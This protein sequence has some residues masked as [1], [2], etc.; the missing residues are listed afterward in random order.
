MNRRALPLA[1]TNVLSVSC[2][3]DAAQLATGDLDAAW[4]GMPTD[5]ILP[6]T[7]EVG[8]LPD[9]L[10][11][12]PDGSASYVL[13]LDVP[14]GRR[15]M[16]PA[17]GLAYN[18]RGGNG[19]FG[20]G[21]SLS[22][23]PEGITR[24]PAAEGRATAVD[25]DDASFCWSGERLVAGPLTDRPDGDTLCVSSVCTEY[26]TRNETYARI[27][28]LGPASDPTA[29]RV[30]TR[31]GRILL[32]ETRVR[33]LQHAS[34]DVE[35][36]ADPVLEGE[37]TLEWALTRELDRRGNSIE[38]SYD[39]DP[40]IPGEPWATHR[41]TEIRYTGYGPQPGNRSVRF[42]YEGRPDVRDRFTSGVQVRLDRRVAAIE[43]WGPNVSGTE[44]LQWRYALDYREDSI[45]GRSLLRLV[46]RSDANGTPEPSTQ[47]DWSLGDFG[48][49]VDE[50]YLPAGASS[51][52][53]DIDGDGRSDL[54]MQPRTSA[55]ASPPVTSGP[56]GD[57][58]W[59]IRLN[60]SA[61]GSG[62][63]GP[64]TCAGF[65]ANPIPIDI[66][67]DGR[68]N[69]IA[70]S[71]TTGIVDT[72]GYGVDP[73]VTYGTATYAA[74]S[75]RTYAWSAGNWYTLQDL[76]GS[77]WPGVYRDGAAP[78]FED[79]ADSLY[80]GDFDG[81]GT[82]DIFRRDFLDTW[83]TQTGR[84]DLPVFEDRDA[85]TLGFD[86][87]PDVPEWTYRGLFR[88]TDVEGDGV[89]DFLVPLTDDPGAAIL[90]YSAACFETAYCASRP[91]GLSA[92]DGAVVGA[93]A[94]A[95]L[96][97]NYRFMDV[98]GDGLDDVVDLRNWLAPT[99]TRPSDG[100]L[101]VRINT[102]N[103]YAPWRSAIEPGYTYYPFEEFPAG[104]QPATV[105]TR[106]YTLD[107][108]LDGLDDFIV[109]GDHPLVYVSNGTTFRPQALPFTHDDAPVTT[110][111]PFVPITRRPPF[112]LA[113]LDGN[114]VAD[115]L[116]GE[117]LRRY[118]RTTALPD[119][120][121]AIR[122][123]FGSRQRIEYAVLRDR[124]LEQSGD[125]RYPIGCGDLRM[126]VVGAIHRDNGLGTSA[127][128]EETS[129]EYTYANPRTDVLRGAFL[130]FQRVRRV[131]PDRGR[132]EE[133]VF[134]HLERSDVVWVSGGAVPHFGLARLPTH[135]ASLTIVGDR[136]I[137]QQTTYSHEEADGAF[138][139]TYELRTS[140]VESEV[141]DGATTGWPHTWPADYTSVPVVAAQSL[142]AS[143][144]E[145]SMPETPGG[146]E[147][148]DR[149]DNSP[150]RRQT[151]TYSN[152]DHYGNARTV[153]TTTLTGRAQVV[154]LQFRPLPYGAPGTGAEE[155]QAQP[156]FSSAVALTD[157]LRRWLISQPDVVTVVSSVPTGGGE[158]ET[159]SV[160][161]YWDDYGL[162]LGSVREP[163][164]PLGD[165]DALQLATHYS[166]DAYG[167]V[168][169]V[170]EVDHTDATDPISSQRTSTFGYDSDAAHLRW[171]RNAAGHLSWIG[172]HPSLGVP[173]I[174]VDANGAQTRWRYDGFGRLREEIGPD[175]SGSVVTYSY[176]N[177]KVTVTANGG[178]STEVMLD[179]L[180]RGVRT[181]SSGLGGVLL[182]SYREYDGLGRVV[183]ERQ[184]RISG[185]LGRAVRPEQDVLGR[186]TAL[187]I[188]P[189]EGDTPELIHSADYDEPG[190]R[191]VRLWDADGETRTLETDY[192]GI[193]AHAQ[194]A[195]DDAVVLDTSYRL[196]PFGVLES[197]IDVSSSE[198]V[199]EHDRLGRPRY[200]EDPDRGPRTLRYN[201]WN[202]LVETDD[203]ERG[204]ISYVRDALGRVVQRSHAHG[205]S[206]YVWDTEP[207]GLGRL[208][209]AI[210]DDG[211]SVE[212]T[213]D[214]LGRPSDVLYSIGGSPFVASYH[215]DG[216]GRVNA[217]DYPEV[218]GARLRVN[219]GYDSSSGL[220]N[221][222]YTS[223]G[224]IFW[225]L[226]EHDGAVRPTVMQVGANRVEQE[227]DPVY[228]MQRRLRVR[229][230]SSPS[231]TP[232][233]DLEANL[234]ADGMLE[235]R[236]DHVSG[237][238][239]KYKYDALD[240]VTSYTVEA[241]SDQ[242]IES[243]R[244]TS[245]GNIGSV[246]TEVTVGGVPDPTVSDDYFYEGSTGGGPHAVSFIERTTGMSVVGLPYGYD[247]IGRQTSGP[248]RYVKFNVDGLPQ[249]VEETAGT[250]QFEYDPFGQRAVT[251]ADDY[252]SYHVGSL[253]ERRENAT[254]AHLNT[255]YV[256]G[257]TGLIAVVTEPDTGGRQ[258][259]Y[260]HADA[261]GT[262]TLVTSATGA[263][264]SSQL[265]NPFGARL[266]DHF[267][268][269]TGGPPTG[270]GRRGFTGH[271]DE[272]EIGLIDMR[273][274]F[275]DPAARRFL[276]P[277]P[278][279][280]D[281]T[282][283]QAFNPYS[284]VSNMGPNGV[285]PS[286]YCT[287]TI[288]GDVYTLEIDGPCRGGPA[289]R[290]FVE[291]NGEPRGLPQGFSTT[292]RQPT[293][294]EFRLLH[295]ATNTPASGMAEPGV[296]SRGSSGTTGQGAARDGFA[297]VNFY[298]D[299]IEEGRRLEEEALMRQYRQTLAG[300]LEWLM[301]SW[302]DSSQD[303]PPWAI[304]GGAAVAG[305]VPGV[306][307]AMDIVVLLN[308]E[309]TGGDRALALVSLSA[310]AMTFGLL[311]NFG[312]AARAARLA[313]SVGHALRAFRGRRWFIGGLN[314]VL[315]SRA[316]R[317]ILERHHPT[318]WNGTIRSTQTFFDPRMSIDD[319]A[320]IAGQV[321][322]QNRDRIMAGAR[323]V[324]AQVGGVWY[325]LGLDHRGRIGQLYPRLV[326]P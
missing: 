223:K 265:F 124:L 110:A 298:T 82:P 67:G 129:E 289:D 305:L 258:T 140:I 76:G 32:F 116:V 96:G 128:P 260:Q 51:L 58:E 144:L 314:V 180:G 296:R 241:G 99:E 316:M 308:P 255:F 123:T 98:N 127:A 228:G 236:F 34:D 270:T 138:V 150:N 23:G 263:V 274:R 84:Q 326:P 36:V 200:V 165:P 322:L 185:A 122:H 256:Y 158:S 194:E 175:G 154:S 43:M 133:T 246:S 2:V 30:E 6:S 190:L 125:C 269:A 92:A 309:S 244:Y 218:G 121:T 171:T 324:H 323:Q 188:E 239:E 142:R 318:W 77:V 243:Y 238:L 161:L 126:E 262:A 279:V 224:E 148:P 65:H 4:P 250:V 22:G 230:G 216:Y 235:S 166:R 319:V 226:L 178:G 307:E 300:H 46:Q 295:E 5:G 10:S 95:G 20:V 162:P 195:D 118:T 18:S 233:V 44:T 81:N 253:Y 62:T 221:K 17:L 102:G 60:T 70:I 267:R 157:R 131:I 164:V 139:G 297:L 168:I 275:Y 208:S 105:D 90:S 37:V 282:S 66:D 64:E 321:L 264:V 35:G 259:Y 276:S 130:G 182:E 53:T 187:R 104:V 278:F 310:N 273:G 83:M 63:F 220:V 172:I 163:L 271:R 132:V 277:D 183:V 191:E 73:P 251:K 120:V 111:G 47:L 108:N 299:Y 213:Y 15:G 42:V 181:G 293:E 94:A 320:D 217:V 203:P 26:R 281:A 13:P 136:S 146:P 137:Y 247:T 103:G 312:M 234:F 210:S 141:Y 212:V 38:Y 284:W 303:L 167:N 248:S 160:A 205:V 29:F 206:T 143:F 33:V 245:D 198:T 192:D 79:F 3:G 59:L 151:I 69:I 86:A 80:A 207:H 109:L 74:A 177:D 50:L 107:Y 153:S 211:H 204:V 301:R 179:R 57:G 283:S 325:T 291:P 240:R 48:V 147:M 174:H 14:A 119:R 156:G 193:L 159:R 313:S 71:Q 89:S 115:F 292:E 56:C 1:L 9:A 227:F 93:A 229:S 317:H 8:G 242:R 232:L 202:E 315:D 201:A 101:R 254:S 88:I 134:G 112:V 12:G 25:F 290:N 106:S 145:A 16:E 40:G 149:W 285:D 72:V 304:A 219:Y 169:Q 39:T 173:L 197:T 155:A 294:R 196:G 306:G 117:T 97:I 75:W 209:Y 280:S 252:T 249:E 61:T 222:I 85:R 45:T 41:L 257:P 52:A 21:F 266:D 302:R 287:R 54:V 11:V 199:Y 272:G 28:G 55:S 27:Y 24:C 7:A 261:L 114:G 87:G 78:S 100:G 176:G 184:H 68:T 91:V 113:D 225:Q 311:P 170:E 135:T 49:S 19:I 214:A 237:R 215:Y 189:H 268:D 231:S 286:G 31:D 186:L 288:A 152:W